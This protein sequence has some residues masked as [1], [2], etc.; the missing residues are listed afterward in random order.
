MAN[1][2][3]NY[4]DIGVIRNIQ[5]NSD[6]FIYECSIGNIPL[7]FMKFVWGINCMMI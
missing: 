7:Y 6:E 4:E 5:N 1:S 3:G 2:I